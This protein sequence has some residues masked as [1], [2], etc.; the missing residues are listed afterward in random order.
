VAIRLASPNAGLASSL[1][2]D[3]R[4]AHVVIEGEWPSPLN[5]P[6]TLSRR[7]RMLQHG[8]VAAAVASFGARGALLA[9][10]GMGRQP[11]MRRRGG[12]WLTVL[13]GHIHRA[14]TRNDAPRGNGTPHR[15]APSLFHLAD[16]RGGS[17]LL[18]ATTSMTMTC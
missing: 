4:E 8:N 15:P 16:S 13:A 11:A 5:R 12:G 1:A 14:L 6:S 3:R 9:C 17:F 7:D 2:L 10:G 18:V